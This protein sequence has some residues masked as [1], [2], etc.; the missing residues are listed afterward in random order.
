MTDY[1][2]IKQDQVTRD[3]IQSSR[4]R[5]ANSSILPNAQRLPAVSRADVERCK[6]HVT[7]HI[8]L[9]RKSSP[10]YYQHLN[11]VLTAN[12]AC[13]LYLFSNFDV[14][15]RYGNQTL[16]DELYEINLK[17]GA[18]LS[19]ELVGTNAAVIAARC[20]TGA[21][22][23]GDDHYIDA[24]KPYA[25]YAF[26]IQGRYGRDGYIML[27][28]RKE[29]VTPQLVELFQ[30]IESTECLITAGL[31]TEDIIIKETMLRNEY[32]KQQTDNIVL[33]VDSSGYI[34]YANEVY[35]E[36]FK[37]D[38]INTINRYLPELRPELRCA[39]ECLKQ[40]R[41]ITGRRVNLNLRAA[42]GSSYL[43]DCLPINAKSKL[44]GV[45][46]TIH[47]SKPEKRSLSGSGNEARYNF[48]DILGVA[49][50]FMQLKRFAERIAPTASPVFISGESGT[51]KE[52]FAHAIHCGSSRHSKP[53]VAINCAAIPKELIGSELFGYVGGSFT[54]AS[55]SGSKGKFELADGGTLFLDEIGEM[56]L[57][58]QSVLL[59]ALEDN[60]ITPIGGS[61]PVPVNV[62][63]ITATNRN[64]QSYIEDGKF[65]ADLYYRINVINL[66]MIP[67]R[68]RRED[69]PI[70]AESFIKRYSENNEMHVNGISTDAMQA[71][72][73]YSW[74]GNIRELRNVIERSVVMCD[75][76][77]IS[78]D[79]LP[80]EITEPDGQKSPRQILEDGRETVGSQ[81]IRKR[82]AYAEKLMEE[83]KGNK[84]KVAKAMGISRSTLYRI[85][86]SS[87]ES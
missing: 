46:I 64:L 83:Y 40:G 35:Y 19:E 74:P 75:G 9:M 72:I 5:C 30:F 53:F 70:L 87:E 61:K 54:G 77:M 24:L 14:F 38:P 8:H 69:I 20:P 32:S 37:G 84:S 43:M 42:E 85:L 2:F 16:K 58:M 57:E 60:A 29:N 26:L 81:F 44:L 4:Y 18:C 76:G 56:P 49:E 28:T 68:H 1:S 36:V 6:G 34:T 80:K 31:V 48:D 7:G 50:N 21:W 82:R 23:I 66:K 13:L 51:G 73:S 10:E 62:R 15:G 59:R 17:L 33:I 63:L 27:I 39:F 45:L 11:D 22:V 67:L 71:L 41:K 3:T 25:C 65:R 52:L 86:G 79:A 47:K 12:K 78:L 55:R